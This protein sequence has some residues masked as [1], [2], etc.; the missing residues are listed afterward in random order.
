MYL[1]DE[2]RVIPPGRLKRGKAHRYPFRFTHT[3]V[4]PPT[5]L[6]YICSVRW[7]LHAVL[8]VPDVPPFLAYRELFLEAPPPFFDMGD[9]EY[10]STVSTAVGEL[11]LVLP[12]VVYAQGEVLRGSMRFN[13]TR[14]FDAEEIR[15]I[16]LRIENLSAGDDHFVYVA[17]W[18]PVTGLFRGERWPG[19]EGTTY[20]WLEAEV[21]LSRTRRFVPTNYL[22][23]PFEFQIPSD[24]RPTLTTGHGRVTWKVGVII[25]R[26]DYPDLRVFH[27]VIVYTA[28]GDY[29]FGE[30]P[31]SG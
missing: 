28:D 15:V 18:D 17:E 3:D 30:M 7:T 5:H 25:P 12:R 22:N 14:E 24:W 2:A 26:P 23:L 13:A 21:V 4:G 27:E 16:L 9:R 8:E 10:H 29:G 20:V 31:S 6:G 19:G 1:Q 11:E